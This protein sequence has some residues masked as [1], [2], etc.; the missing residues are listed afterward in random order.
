MKENNRQVTQS[1]T[2]TESKKVGV[3]MMNII[4]KIMKQ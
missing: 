3:I 1:G 4:K 2:L